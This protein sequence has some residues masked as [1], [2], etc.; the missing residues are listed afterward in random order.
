VRPL[1]QTI[2]T[3]DYFD[4]GWVWLS[5]SVH[6]TGRILQRF[7]SRGRSMTY[8]YWKT[9]THMQEGITSIVQFSLCQ[10][11]NPQHSSCLYRSQ[12]PFHSHHCILDELLAEIH[13]RKG[14]PEAIWH[15]RIHVN[16]R[17]RSVLSKS[18][19]ECDL[20]IM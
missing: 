4:G 13:G 11:K 15:V 1:S 14:S 10:F 16:L 9:C 5:I 6:S 17:L 12:Q 20:F 8:E 3:T 19:L 18:T 2:S 7:N